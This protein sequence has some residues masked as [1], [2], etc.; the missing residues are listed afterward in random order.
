[1]T[2]QTPDTR[3]DHTEALARIIDHDEECEHEA[4]ARD[5]GVYITC[6]DCA[7]SRLLDPSNRAV[8][9]AAL[10]DHGTLSDDLRGD[11]PCADCGTGDNIVW[12]TEN[13]FWNAVME[14]TNPPEHGNGGVLCIP[15]F[16]KR[17]DAAG[18]W[19]TG[20]RLIPEFH[21]E[22]KTDRDRRREVRDE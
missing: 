8:L 9:I 13:T 11:G 21:R 16:V 19:P 17:T 2:E 7:A 10:T 3:P 15:C 18:Y 5:E 20:W 1:M 4:A 12:F 22:T 14:A 6:S